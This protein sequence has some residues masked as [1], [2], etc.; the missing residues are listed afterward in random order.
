MGSI[1]LWQFLLL[2]AICVIVLIGRR[3]YWQFGQLRRELG[4]VFPVF[5]AETTKSTEAEFIREPLPG[6]VPVWVLIV[7]TIAVCVMVLWLWQ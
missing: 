5:S 3:N 6:R 7:A 2:L 1:T 4:D